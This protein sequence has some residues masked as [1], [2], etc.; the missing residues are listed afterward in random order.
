LDVLVIGPVPPPVDGRAVATSWLVDA[1][2]ADGQAVT[3]ADTQ[4]GPITKLRSCLGAA[5]VLLT[6]RRPDRV[7]VVASGGAGLAIEMIPLL[8]ARIRRVSSTLTHHSS[9]YVRDSS[10]TLRV[11]LAVAG[12]QLRHV[13]LDD[14]MGAELSSRYGIDENQVV[15][16]DNAGLMPLPPAP[17]PDAVRCG[18]LHLSNLSADKGLAAVLEV[19]DRTGIAVRLVGPPSKGAAVLLDEASRRGVPFTAV[20]PRHGEAKVRELTTARCLV[21]PSSY[22][23]EAQPLVLYEAAAAGCVPIV[24]RNGWIGEQLGRLGLDEYVFSL[25][26]VDG[27]AAAVRRVSELDDASF[28]ESSARVR[29]AFEA[30]HAR[31]GRQFRALVE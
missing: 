20:G 17:D 15:V 12:S 27:V 16:V 21:F 31:T 25:G 3:V 10:W 4:A 13:V 1:L 14:A 7:V 28:A 22:R 9:R 23:H 5:L 24:W 6:G 8:A 2:R 19:A 30:Q 29:A 18:V 11:A 26:D